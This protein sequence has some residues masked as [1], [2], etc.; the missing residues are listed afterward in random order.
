MVND[1]NK[2]PP[3]DIVLSDSVEEDFIKDDFKISDKV[4][5]LYERN[6]A[7]GI[8]T[9][10]KLTPERYEAIVKYVRA[11]ACINHAANAVGIDDKTLYQWL[12]RGANETDTIFSLFLDDYRRAKSFAVIRNVG[13]VQRAA[14]DDW[15]AAKWLLQVLD[16]DVYGNKS[17]IKTEISGPDGENIKTELIISDDELKKLAIIQNMIEEQNKIVDAD[18]KIVDDCEEST[19][20][21]RSQD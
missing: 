4:P 3:K 11:G 6:N 13:I 1:T 15:T 19:E 10:G 2:T 20:D 17:T 7:I 8:G 14:D 9:R 12:R 5:A 18:Y 16:P 21:Y